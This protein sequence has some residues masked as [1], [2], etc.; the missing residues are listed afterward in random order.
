MR[1]SAQVPLTL[2]ASA[3]LATSHAA[4]GEPHYSALTKSVPAV[5]SIAAVERGG[6][7]ETL[8]SWWPL[9]LVAPIVAAFLIRFSSGGE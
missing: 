7:G 2:L 5:V 9:V 6:F 8:A 3:A 1:K 4:S